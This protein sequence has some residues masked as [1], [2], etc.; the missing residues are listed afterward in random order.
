M[1]E[2]QRVL[3]EDNLPVG[4]SVLSRDSTRMESS[5]A[6]VIIYRKGD[7]CQ[8]CNSFLNQR[9]PL[10]VCSLCL[11]AEVNWQRQLDIIRGVKPL[12]VHDAKDKKEAPERHTLIARAIG[13]LRVKF[14]KP[15]KPKKEK[16]RWIIGARI[17]GERSPDDWAWSDLLHP[18][19]M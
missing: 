4:M 11:T 12:R 5:D 9:N 6:G 2:N 8:W 14:R 7:R 15:L 17:K 16:D 19:N 3:D 10:N 13:A 18:V 1:N